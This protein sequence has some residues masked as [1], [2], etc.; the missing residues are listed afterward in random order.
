MTC[1][2]IRESRFVMRRSNEPRGSRTWCHANEITSST[3]VTGGGWYAYRHL[4]VLN[5]DNFV[6]FG[7]C[8][9][10]KAKSGRRCKMSRHLRSDPSFNRFSALNE[11]LK[12]L[13]PPVVSSSPQLSPQSTPGTSP[14]LPKVATQ[15]PRLVGTSLVSVDKDRFTSDPSA[16]VVTAQSAM[17]VTAQH[18][19]ML[20][21]RCLQGRPAQSKRFRLDAADGPAI[22]HLAV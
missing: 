4:G 5:R 6:G 17:V 18:D 22:L 2:P 3:D 14:A 7:K 8:A 13:E 21:L 11:K 15:P 1:T 20:A 9:D 16:M 19:A 12:R 10:A